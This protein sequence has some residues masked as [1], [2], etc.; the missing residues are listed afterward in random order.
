LHQQISVHPEL[1]TL[2]SQPSAT[3]KPLEHIEV[4][5]TIGSIGAEGTFA[6]N[7]PELLCISPDQSDITPTLTVHSVGLTGATGLLFTCSSL[8]FFVAL[9]HYKLMLSV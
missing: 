8:Q 2:L 4:F 3:L 7:L 1:N 9:T 5:F 6:K